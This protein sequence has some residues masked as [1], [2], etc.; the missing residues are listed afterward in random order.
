MRQLA[1]GYVTQHQEPCRTCQGTGALDCKGSSKQI[2]TRVPRHVAGEV[3]ADKDKCKTCKGEKVVK[4]KK[5]LEVII[6][7]GM[8]HNQKIV[9]SG[10]ADEAVRDL[11]L[12]SIFQLTSCL[13]AVARHNHWRCGCDSASQRASRL[14]TRRQESVHEEADIAVRSAGWLSGSLGFHEL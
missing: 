7:R 13:S 1:P 3:I 6:E 14:Q 8:E 5:T 11:L 10:E 9:F 2:L 12:Q 4:E